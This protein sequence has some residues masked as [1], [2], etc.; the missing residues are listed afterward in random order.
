MSKTHTASRPENQPDQRYFSAAQA[1]SY[2]GVTER[3]VWQM[4]A[5]GRLKTYRLGSRIVRFRIDDIDAALEAGG[6]L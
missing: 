1:A 4:A 3:C 6:D 5:D 2:I